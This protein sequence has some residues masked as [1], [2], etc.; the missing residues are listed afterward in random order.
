MSRSPEP[1]SPEF[2]QLAACAL[3]DDER[4]AAAA[5][6]AH[7]AGFDWDR[8]VALGSFHGVEQV[9]RARLESALP[10][11]IHEPHRAR[12]QRQLL[13]AAALNAAHARAAVR[14]VRLLAEAGIAAR[15]FFDQAFQSII[16]RNPK[17]KS[18]PSRRG[19]EGDPSRVSP[20]Q[21]VGMYFA[22]A[23]ATEAR[24]AACRSVCVRSGL[25]NRSRCLTERMHSSLGPPPTM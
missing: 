9:A 1:L 25:E 16:F 17:S 13:Q 6:L 23:S 18:T 24:R 22:Q 4:L 2:A 12:L 20:E 5:P 11:A 15:R 21:A 19:A 8:F 14:T 10:G 7:G 3:L